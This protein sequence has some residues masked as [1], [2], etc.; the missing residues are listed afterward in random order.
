MFL[1]RA[2]L[3]LTP[4]Q[5]RVFTLRY[6]EDLSLKEIACKM[7]RSI[8]TVKAHLFQ[9]HRKL[10]EMLLPYLQNDRFETWNSNKHL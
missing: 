6:K 3:E 1:R 7:E 9:I 8:G 4:K 10:K 5:R 2:V